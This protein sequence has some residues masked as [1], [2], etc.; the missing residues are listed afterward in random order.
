M[1]KRDVKNYVFI[2]ILAVL[3]YVSFKIIQPFLT[4]L[5]TSFLFAYLFYPLYQRL[6]KRI[7]KEY[8]SSAITVIIMVLVFLIPAII[9]ADI[10]I[11]E[12]IVIMQNENIIEEVANRITSYTAL[13]PILPYLESAA[14]KAISFLAGI[15]ADMIV[16]VPAKIINLLI[17]IFSVFY[18][19]IV[20]KDFINIMTKLLPFKNKQEVMNQIGDVAYSVVYGIFA[21]AVLEF[22]MAAIGLT[23][24]HIKV[25]IIWALLV[26]FV[27]FIPMLGPFIILLP[28]MI[29]YYLMGDYYTLIGL[30][31]LWVILSITETV[32][33][34][35]I[36]GD[37]S[38][39]NPVIILLGILGGVG[40]FGFIGLIA[41]PIILSLII[42]LVKEYYPEAE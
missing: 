12:T 19:L 24:L 10:V 16:T 33:K 39:L 35:K 21:V 1:E 34:P 22:V 6:N 25:P 14:A 38:K 32:L 9:I 23:L 27:I 13:Q 36:I 18:L 8:I 30:I 42:T 28:L 40:L 17:M 41:G 2:A 26:G 15:A 37:K 4:A 29:A 31:I 5:I 20:G 3:I 7:K 11:K